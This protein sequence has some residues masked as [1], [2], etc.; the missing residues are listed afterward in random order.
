MA[1]IEV[2]RCMTLPLRRLG[3]FLT[4]SDPDRGR[5]RLALGT[6]A[7]LL[8]VAA[9]L[10]LLAALTGQSITAAIP[11]IILAMIA[12]MAVRENKARPRT[13]TI[14]LLAPAAF[15]SITIAV[16][17]SADMVIADVGFV[18]VAVTAVLVRA[19]GPRGLAMGMLAFMC[20]F[21]AIF[22]KI[23]ASQLPAVAV[24]LT[25]SALVTS[26]MRQLT[27]PRH[28]DRDIQRML[29]A[30][31]ERARRVVVT[32][33]EAVEAGEFHEHRLRMLRSRVA[34]FGATAT[35]IEE[36]LDGEN[37]PVI[38]GIDNDEL[39]VRIF[40][41]QLTL[42]RVAETITNTVVA[43]NLTT[44]QQ[45][46]L[47]GTLENLASTLAHPI[48]TDRSEDSA[49][50]EDA[51]QGRPR[52]TVSEASFGKITEDERP[53]QVGRV[54]SAATTAWHRVA[55]TGGEAT[56]SIPR[57]R[58]ADKSP[59]PAENSAG[60]HGFGDVWRQAVQVGV[61]AA[62]A[63]AAGTA[64]S[65]ARWF[66]A[67]TS[68]FVVYVGTS[69]RGEILTKGGLRVLGTLGGVV[70]GV[71]IAAF[72]GHNTIVA[73]VLVVVSLFCGFYLS[74]V[75]SAFMI[76]FI[77]TMLALLYGLLGEF[78]IGLL[79]TRLEETA[80]GAAIGVGVAYVVL[81]TPTR[82]VARAKMRAFLETLSET[83]AS[84]TGRLSSTVAAGNP[85][86]VD[87]KRLRSDYQALRTSA[88]PVAHGIAGV[89]DQRGSRRSLRILAVCEYH[90][91]LLLRLA[92]QP[93][94]TDDAAAL[95]TLLTNAA[96][97]VS[98]NIDALRLGV[99]GRQSDIK[100]VPAS[101]ILDD[102][103]DYA[104]KH[105]SMHSRELMTV[106]R[107]LR[108]IDLAI[109]TRAREL[110]ATITNQQPATDSRV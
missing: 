35:S 65:S 18:A 20:Y 28:V 63:I 46:T 88:K 107:N 103:E 51:D 54:L 6:I 105:G 24:A 55:V 49:T 53:V 93:L 40:D 92:D 48:S 76:F 71:L 31:G 7:T 83:I 41:F 69:S 62:L 14:L 5:L 74:S 4:T 36:A 22:V 68:A 66:W 110:G 39:A 52:S 37:E 98:S 38:A 34:S 10:F 2:V 99:G 29:S 86:L 30:L 44:G 101:S 108:A 97:A 27:T 87:A 59:T 58:A 72:V 56:V 17:L 64:L 45:S 47:R 26:L 109:G 82:D 81:P 96:E 33:R 1:Q 85:G 11:G 12:S 42:E 94:I 79:L 80:V 43:F 15:A 13:V 95:K 32:L 91:R 3:R 102:F 78:S 60:F 73:L 21:L 89:S 8:A 9:V 25:L 57:Q 100:I 75:S 106:S 77:T 19:F 16:F 104:E 50:S 90:G 61:A 84:A 23:S 70:F 67:V